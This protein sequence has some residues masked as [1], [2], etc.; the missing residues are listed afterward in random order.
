MT[1]LELTEVNALVTEIK[2]ISASNRYHKAK[3][4]VLNL[5][6][7]YFMTEEV[8]L[9][10]VSNIGDFNQNLAFDVEMEFLPHK[11]HDCRE[12]PVY[13]IQCKKYTEEQAS[14]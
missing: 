8:L 3:H 2:G 14:A 12:N 10:L 6:G 7:K 11:T 4:K 9:E 5:L 1:N 13:T